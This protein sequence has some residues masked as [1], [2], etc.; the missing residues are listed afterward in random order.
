MI[1]SRFARR[2]ESLEI[3]SMDNA[4]VAARLENLDHRVD[5]IEQI[6]PT[7]ATKEDL[8]ATKEDVRRE[9]QLATEPLATKEE[10]R[11][12][13]APLA[14]KEGLERAIAPLATKE[15]LARAIAP[16][17]TKEEL[18]RA[19]APLATKEELAR[20]VAPLATREELRRAI[21]PL[22]TK[23]QFEQLDERVVQ[24]RVL[25]EEQRSDIRLLADHLARL[26]E[27]VSRS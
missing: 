1:R 17:A 14:T 25:V 22:A 13:I 8:N 3:S 6:L 10:L 7:L 23:V 27:K 21:E 9:V 4:T 26:S 16:L 24:V 19:I 12:A 5:R 15:E 2:I 18:A 11:R 20:A